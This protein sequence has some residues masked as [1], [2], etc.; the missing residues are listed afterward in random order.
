MPVRLALALVALFSVV[1]LLSLGATYLVTQ[2]SLDATM[3]ADLTQDMAGFRAA[4]SAAA[5][6]QLVEAEAAVTDPERMILSY[7]APNRRHFGNAA[8]ARDD[9]GYHVVTGSAEDTPLDGRYMAL[10]ATLR[11]GQLTIARS[12]ADI[13]TLGDAFWRVVGLS[14]I[15]TVLIALSGGYY[16]ARRSARIVQTIGVTLDRLTGGTL[17]ARVR[18][19]PGWPT[20]LAAIGQRIDTMAEAQEASVTAIRQVSSDIAHDLKTPIQRVAVHLNDLSDRGGL[21]GPSEELL[22]KAKVELDGIA[23]VFHSLLQ[24]AQIETGSPKAGFVPIDLCALCTTFHE[25]YEPAAIEA[26]CTLDVTLADEGAFEVA[27]DRGLLGQVLANLIENALRHTPRGTSVTIALSRSPT[28]ITLSVSDDGPGVPEAERDLVLRRLYRMDRS[29]TS[30]GSGLGLSFVSSVAA[31]HKARVRLAD[32][33]PG[34]RV[35][36]DFRALPLQPE[37]QSPHKT[38]ASSHDAAPDLS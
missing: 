31:L 3:R 29:R 4:P 12:M 16:L 38:N 19:A 6:A 24:I 8:I 22:D 34:L 28:D 18:P 21:D 27:G 13:E 23:S 36:I 17:D 14:L 37:R 26:G 32:N 30:P 20:D 33:K 1:S 2:R 10:T 35:I 9:D 25:L 7:F 11:G 15:P 5:L